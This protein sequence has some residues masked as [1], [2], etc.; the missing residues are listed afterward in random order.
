MRPRG[1]YAHQPCPCQNVKKLL[2]EVDRLVMAGLVE[3]CTPDPVHP[4]VVGPAE[5]HGRAEPNV[6]V[7]A[8]LPGS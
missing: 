4:L 6:E 7:A 8:D 1:L 3:L 5:E 2:L